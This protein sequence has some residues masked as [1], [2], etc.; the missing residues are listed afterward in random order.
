M[1][2]KKSLSLGED[3][4]P[5]DPLHSEIWGSISNSGFQFVILEI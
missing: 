4:V 2:D 5:K 1:V 3:E